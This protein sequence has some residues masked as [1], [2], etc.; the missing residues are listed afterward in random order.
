MPLSVDLYAMM[1][2]ANP[3]P[4][5]R[6]TVESERSLWKREI[7]SLSAMWPM[8]LLATPRLPSLFSKSIGF[9]LWGIVDEPISPAT[10]RCLK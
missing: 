1:Q 5:L 6:R 10:T 7:G 9:T 3:T 8:T 2:C 4:T